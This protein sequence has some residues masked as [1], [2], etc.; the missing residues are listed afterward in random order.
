MNK[1]INDIINSMALD[2]EKNVNEYI[3]VTN[4]NNEDEEA[5]V[6]DQAEAIVHSYLRH[7]YGDKI[8]EA[9]AEELIDKLYG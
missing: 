2:L 8:S 6:Y 9:M 4:F 1:N 5:M 3:I 7:G